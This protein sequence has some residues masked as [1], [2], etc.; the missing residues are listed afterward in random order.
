MWMSVLPMF[1]SKS[2][3]VS[4]LTFRF[5]IHIEFIFVHFFTELKQKFSQIVCKHRRPQIAKTIMKKKN[6]VG[7][8]NLTDFRLYTKL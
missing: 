6:A 3:I 8:I 1:S 2:F 5:L 7:G 4:C